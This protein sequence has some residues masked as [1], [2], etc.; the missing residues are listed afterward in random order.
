V[1]EKWGIKKKQHKTGDNLDEASNFGVPYFQTKP[2]KGLLFFG[3][4][5]DI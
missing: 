2:N 1:A 4:N 5:A 3:F